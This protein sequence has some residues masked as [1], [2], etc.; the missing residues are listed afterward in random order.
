M[1]SAYSYV[2]LI[3]CITMGFFFVYL[4]PLDMRI[5]IECLVS[6]NLSIPSAWNREEDIGK[7]LLW[8][9]DLG[10]VALHAESE[11]GE[12]RLMGTRIASQGKACLWEENGAFFCRLIKSCSRGHGLVSEEQSEFSLHW[13][14]WLDIFVQYKNSTTVHSDSVDFFTAGSDT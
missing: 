6:N 2:I 3:T 8:V 14:A 9:E 11:K 1:L 13:P 4:S 5:G 12:C 10:K 7:D